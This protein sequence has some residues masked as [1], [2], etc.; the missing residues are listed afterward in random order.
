M[1][2]FL[3]YRLLGAYKAGKT[4]MNSLPN[5]KTCSPWHQELSYFPPWTHRKLL[6]GL[7]LLVLSTQSRY[8]NNNSC[9]WLTVTMSKR[10]FKAFLP[11]TTK[12]SFQYKRWKT[13][14][15]NIWQFAQS[16]SVRVKIVLIQDSLILLANSLD[17]GCKGLKQ[18]KN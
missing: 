8:Y 9:H 15:R 18:K 14:I 1:Q 16:R 10:L 11:K 13:E 5:L 2:G 12:V 4:F 7:G 3:F 17:R 6:N